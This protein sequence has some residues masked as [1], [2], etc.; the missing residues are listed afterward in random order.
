M[1][2]AHYQYYLLKLQRFNPDKIPPCELYGELVSQYQIRNSW[3]CQE[4][5]DYLNQLNSSICE[6][7]PSNFYYKK[8]KMLDLSS[9][10]MSIL[11]DFTNWEYK[12]EVEDIYLYN[13]PE[14]SNLE[15]LTHFKNL[16]KIIAYKTNISDI[17]KLSENK[18]LKVLDFENTL[19]KNVDSLLT[20]KKLK[21]VQMSKTP[22]SIK[23][24]EVLQT[25]DKNG[26]C[27]H[28]LD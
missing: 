4:W 17:S 23:S 26:V 9:R 15:S 2:L 1:P 8:S 10:F 27:V 12:N 11:P 20:L 16:E 7:N 13:N 6:L 22:A 5:I 18:N 28:Y 14:L 21:W 3:T 19:I 24:A 25:L